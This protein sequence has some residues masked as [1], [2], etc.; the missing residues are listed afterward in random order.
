MESKK[1][2][3]RPL[4]DNYL[5]VLYQKA[6]EKWAA[7][8]DRQ[9]LRLGPRAVKIL[10]VIVTTFFGT[11]CLLLIISGGKQFYSKPPIRPEII[12]TIKVHPA[13]ID[14][15]TPADSLVIRQVNTFR[16]YMDTLSLSKG[17]RK[18]R[19]SILLAR[20]GLLDSI[21]IVESMYNIKK[22]ESHEK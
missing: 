3:S 13:A 5:Q 7:W 12:Q 16:A 14:G 9:S 4:L 8:M 1:T 17:G 21:R 6:R 19:D 10:F 11:V 20:P 2:P 15:A 18:I 22:N